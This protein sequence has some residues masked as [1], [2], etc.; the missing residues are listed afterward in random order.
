MSR[1]ETLRTLSAV[2]EKYNLKFNGFTAKGHLRWKHGPT[3]RTIVT[4]SVFSG[5]HSYQNA[6]RGIKQQLR[7]AGAFN[8]QHANS[9]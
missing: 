9:N 3:D 1:R 4:V 6:I 5:R 7:E 8:G 2:A